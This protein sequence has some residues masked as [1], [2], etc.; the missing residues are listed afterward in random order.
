MYSFLNFKSKAL[1]HMT[2]VDFAQMGSQEIEIIQRLRG[3]NPV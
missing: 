1:D 3:V 2:V